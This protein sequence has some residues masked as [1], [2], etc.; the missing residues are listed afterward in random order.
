MG[1]A[2]LLYHWGLQCHWNYL[3]LL[4]LGLLDPVMASLLGRNYVLFS[5]FIYFLFLDET[6]NKL[7]MFFIILAIVGGYAFVYEGI[8]PT[9]LLGILAVMGNSLFFFIGNAMTK[10]YCE[11]VDS[12]LILF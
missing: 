5:L 7:Q 10:K 12:T 6:I 11:Q 9:S 1:E 2:D 3:S 8:N 4:D